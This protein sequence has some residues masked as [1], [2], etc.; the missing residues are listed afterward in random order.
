MARPRKPAQRQQR[1]RVRRRQ[2]PPSFSFPLVRSAAL[3]AVLKK[4]WTPSKLSCVVAPTGY[5]KTV[6]SSAVSAQCTK[7]GIH[8]L[9]LSLDDRDDSIERV[10]DVLQAT[11]SEGDDGVHPAQALI[12]GDEPLENR[13][14]DLLETLAQLP[15]PSMIIID[16]LGYC[17]DETLGQL[18]ER[19]VYQTPSSVHFWF[20][21]TQRVPM[22]VARA[23]LQGAATEYGVE[24]LSLKRQE[25]SQ[26]LGT[27]LCKTLGADAIERVT[28][29][30]EG[31]PAAVRLS[32]IILESSENPLEALEQF[33]GADEDLSNLLNR[34][35]LDS[36]SKEMLKFLLELSLLRTFS[37]ELAQEA[38]GDAQ[39]GT[40][41]ALLL[42]R[43]VFVIPLDR[44]GTWHRLH[45]LFREFL[46]KEAVQKLSLN[47]RRG[48]LERAARWCDQNGQWNIAIDYALEA[49]SAPL[50]SDILERAAPHFVR[51]QGD[52][53]QYIAW[54]ETLRSRGHDVGWEADYWYVWALVF[55]RRYDFA[56]QQHERLA[57]RIEKEGIGGQD[58]Q[59]LAEIKR[60]VDVIRICIDTYTDDLAQA[61]KLTSAWLADRAADDPFDV[62]TVAV[63]A[64]LYLSNEHRFAEARESARTARA[65]ITQASS[66]Y[67]DA[68]V[69]L[70]SCMNTMLEGNFA[71]A[72]NDVRGALSKARA[73][74][75]DS[76]GMIGTASLVAAKCAV[77]IGRE[78]EAREL[79]ASGLRRANNHGVLDTAAIGADAALKLWTGRD[80]DIICITDLRDL[81]ANYPPRMNFML[82]CFVI[83]R[84]LRLGRLEDAQAEAELA[85][86][87]RDKPPAVAQSSARVR[88]LHALTRIELAI[89]SGQ[90]RQAA[91]LINTQTRLAR[92]QGCSAQLLDLAL[93]DMSLA[94]ATQKAAQA[95][96][97]LVRAIGLGAKRGILR[98]FRERAELIA[99][100]VNNTRPQD[101][102]FALE[103]ERLFFVEICRGLP[104][105][106]ADLLEELKQTYGDETELLESPTSRELEL[107]RLI[108]VGLSN[109]QLADRLNVSVATVKWHLYNLYAKLGVSSRSAALA[110]ARALNLLGR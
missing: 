58:E 6:L 5:G 38:S 39:A 51:D 109:Q 59:R 48:V 102:G 90:H 10:V 29:Q 54:V 40:H 77:E 106:N 7:Q 107:L 98:P 30:T 87:G 72:Y 85:G 20:A 33:S 92:D 55:H 46:H 36:F 3:A 63:A 21:S 76:S 70:S 78:D 95:T 41:V 44:N 103:E 84:L 91:P 31:W 53:R 67:G 37:V 108:E 50:A 8:T 24:E 27:Q 66:V 68:W 62:A 18:L 64:M 52:L 79:L 19:L 35:V 60:R 93:S 94:L 28:R 9:W 96:K 74:L 32:Q 17:Q 47:H 25:V 97:H 4:N 56:R 49:N 34:Q 14:D 69:S 83:Q 57:Q 26:L 104:L 22:N 11:L 2:D 13:I 99:S 86:L 73:A 81:A 110:R 43:N 23:K 89:A 71:V 75:G 42:R 61:H 82:S 12:H 16:N 1:G 65:A 45:G 105:G 100:L 15:E 80:D 88:M 101:W